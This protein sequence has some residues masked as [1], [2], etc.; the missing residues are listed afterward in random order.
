MAHK[1]RHGVR[2]K[3]HKKKRKKTAKKAAVVTHK[4]PRRKRK[5]HYAGAYRAPARG[6]FG[7]YKVP[8]L[9]QRSTWAEH[10]VPYKLTQVGSPPFGYD[11][12]NIQRL[13]RAA[14]LSEAADIATSRL[15]AARINRL[16]FMAPPSAGLRAP[17]LHPAQ[18][19]DG[20][21]GARARA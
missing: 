18:W 7:K 20:S 1:S 10:E 16:R 19:D 11:R 6:T 13:R 21:R 9:M 15:N 2:A 8:A 14:R 17:R 4:V 3:R 12:W 5:R